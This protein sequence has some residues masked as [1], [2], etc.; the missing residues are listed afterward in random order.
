[1]WHT[2]TNGDGTPGREYISPDPD[3]QL[4]EQ[5]NE[6]ERDQAA[7]DAEIDRRFQEWRDTGIKPAL[8]R[9]KP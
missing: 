6:L 9:R 8:P 2:I 4:E 7:Y 1:M 3:E 5:Q